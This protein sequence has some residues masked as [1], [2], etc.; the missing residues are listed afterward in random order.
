[1][2]ERRL[3]YARTLDFE[4]AL[5]LQLLKA[6]LPN[7]C[8]DKKQFLKWWEAIALAW[9]EELQSVT[10]SHRSIGHDW[11][12]SHQQLEALKH[13]YDANCL[14]LPMAEIQC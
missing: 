14:L 9:T 3:A 10:I 12:F 4:L 7:N 6:Q 13:Y 1:V 8:R 2:L 5:A 11:Q